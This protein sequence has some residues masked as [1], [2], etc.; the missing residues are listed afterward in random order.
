MAEQRGN[1]LGEWL[2]NHLRQTGES[3]YGLSQRMGVSHSTIGAI[4]KGT[5]THPTNRILE[6]LSDATGAEF[7]VLA[8]LATSKATREY[9]PEAMI[10][11][12]TFDNLPP[13]YQ[14]LLLGLAREVESVALQGGERIKD[15]SQGS[16]R[17]S[18]KITKKV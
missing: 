14:K 18:V 10:I 1:L 11:A 5:S 13:A 8:G 9:S 15:N 2:E 4:I 6:L 17:K 12:N 7:H 16:G 3:V